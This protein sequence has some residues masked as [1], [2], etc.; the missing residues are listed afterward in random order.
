[1]TPGFRY[2]FGIVRPGVTCAMDRTG[3]YSPID[4][5]RRPSLFAF[6]NSAVLKSWLFLDVCIYRLDAAGSKMV[7]GKIQEPAAPCIRPGRQPFYSRRPPVLPTTPHTN[8]ITTTEPP[9]DNAPT[10]FLAVKTTMRDQTGATIVKVR[11]DG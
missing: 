11:I 1:V 7:H 4:D 6:R 9:A 5:R 8:P 3:A 10:R 2:S